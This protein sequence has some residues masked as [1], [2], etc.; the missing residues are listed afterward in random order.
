MSRIPRLYCK[1]P[2]APGKEIDLPDG[3][4][5]HAVRVMRLIR[6]DRVILFNGDGHDYDAELTL[7]ARSGARARIVAAG[8]IEPP[9]A[10]A[11]HLALGVSR[12]QRM[13]FALQK[14][15]EL[16]VTRCT[17]LFTTRSVVQ[18][19]DERLEQRRAHWHQVTIA[20]CEQS[21]RRRLPVLDPPQTF[22]SWIESWQ[23]QGVLLDPDADNSLTELSPPA[24]KLTLLVGPE[25]G[26]TPEERM[27]AEKQG[28]RG[29]RLGPF[30]LRTETAP[31]AAIAAIQALWGNFR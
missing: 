20:A 11:L 26:L 27:L 2:L 31:L 1:T 21:G 22:S 30:I 10:L 15:T 3:P 6:G 19:K 14:A 4:A 25:G 9:P 24:E 29:V 5:R 7:A 18:L 17:P 12:G 8:P 13:D 28:L 23:G 16:G